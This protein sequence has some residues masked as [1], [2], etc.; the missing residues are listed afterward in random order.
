MT[1]NSSL[2]YLITSC[3]K[4]A[5]AWQVLRDHFE[6]DTLVNKLMFPKKCQTFSKSEHKAKPTYMESHEEFHLDSEPRVFGASSQ[7]YNLEKWIVDSRTSNH[8]TIAI[9]F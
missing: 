9:C 5:D 4:P 8:M 7:S 2:T 1:I 6:R 3:E